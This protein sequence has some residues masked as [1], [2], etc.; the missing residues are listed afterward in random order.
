MTWGHH[1]HILARNVFL[2]ARISHGL[3]LISQN[4]AVK[5]SVPLTS[6]LAFTR[7]VAGLNVTVGETPLFTSN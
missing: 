1:I 5:K 4:G 7:H 2:L 6:L 3:S